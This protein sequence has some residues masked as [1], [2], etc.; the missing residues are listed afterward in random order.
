MYVIDFMEM[1]NPSDR[2]VEHRSNPVAQ[3][4]GVKYFTLLEA[5][6]LPA[7][8]LEVLERVELGPQS[9]V[10]RLMSIKYNDLTSVAKTHLPDAVKKIIEENEK[11]FVEFF[12]IGE[13]VNIRM[14][15]FELLPSIGKKTMRSLV[16]ERNVKRFE[17]FDDIR[18]RVKIDPVKTLC[19][20]ILKELE[21]NEKYYIFVKPPDKQGI[22]LGYLERLYGE[23]F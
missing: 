12:N 23:L 8:R 6:P 7:I 13:P 16:E 1:G 11:I 4:I 5:T 10:R 22:Y 3:G 2:H 21:G 14:H 19:E 9:K 20:R 15:V 18:D 17:S